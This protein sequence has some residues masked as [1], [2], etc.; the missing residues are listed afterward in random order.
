MEGPFPGPA[1]PVFGE[2]P[3]NDDDASTR[4][5]STQGGPCHPK[6]PRVDHD[7]NHNNE[8]GSDSESN[9]SSYQYQSDHSGSDDSSWQSQSHINDQPHESTGVEE[10]NRPSG[11]STGVEDNPDQNQWPHE[12]TGVQASECGEVQEDEAPTLSDIFKQAAD[13]GRL[14]AAQQNNTHNL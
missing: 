13:T 5:Q 8:I 11:E 2:A 10:D 6:N 3:A 7:N 14:A 9:D 12:N 4:S 1:A